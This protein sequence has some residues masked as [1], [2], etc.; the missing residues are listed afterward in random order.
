LTNKG[1]L[2]RYVREYYYPIENFLPNLL[3]PADSRI[4][5]KI[6]LVIEVKI[7]IKIDPDIIHKTKITFKIINNDSKIMVYLPPFL[8][9][10]KLSYK[11]DMILLFIYIGS[12][13]IVGIVISTILELERYFRD[14][15]SK[16]NFINL[17][18]S[19]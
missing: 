9:K 16:E 7:L 19:T 15:N 6:F 3:V 4:S 8:Y 10:T 17:K 12:K 11:E 14:G 13:N 1:N 5:S 18:D 2:K